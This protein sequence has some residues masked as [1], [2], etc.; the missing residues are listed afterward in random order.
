MAGVRPRVLF[1]LHLPPPTHGS[2]LVGL[3]IKESRLIGAEFDGAFINLLASR[4]VAESG[5]ISAGKAFRFALTWWAVLR[6]LVLSRPRMC[7]LALS[8]TGA[9]FVR[10]VLIIALLRV[11][12]IRRVFHLHNKGVSVQRSFLLRRVLYPFAFGGAEIILLSPRLYLDIDRYVPRDRIHICP[13]GIDGQGAEVPTGVP[14][15]PGFVQLLFLS[16]LIASKGVFELLDACVLL[17]QQGLAFRCSLVGGEGDVGAARLR[18]AIDERGLGDA[19]VY[20]GPRYG[21]DKQ[22]SLRGAEIFVLP[23]YYPSECFPLVLLEAMSHGLA[24]VTTDEGGIADIVD[25]GATGYVVPARDPQALAQRLAVLIESPELRRR[26]GAEGRHKF[27]RDFTL[28]SFE[29]R[30]RDILVEVARKPT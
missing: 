20:E 2:S 18:A 21:E 1:L 26:M 30:L 6:Q 22:A 8:T 3:S 29:N 14:V 10:D 7:Y 5:R 19:A 15:H 9:A 4:K 28:E 12:G 13:N 11:F 16:N 23:T 25:E 17:K 27:L 24:V